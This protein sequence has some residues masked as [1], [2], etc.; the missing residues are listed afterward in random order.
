MNHLV[1]RLR[2]R[3][4]AA[5]L[6]AMLAIGPAHA[7]SGTSPAPPIIPVTPAAP[8]FSPPP[9]GAPVPP[10]TS[11]P[12]RPAVQ[13]PVAPA[14]APPSAVVPPASVPPGSMPP[15][16]T[17]PALTPPALTPPALTPPASTPPAA[18]PAAAPA[19]APPPPNIWLPRTAVSLEALDKVTARRTALTGKV[20]DTLHFGSLSIVVRACVVRP[21]DQPADAA[22]SLDITDAHAGAPGFDGWLFAAEPEISMFAHPL[23]DIRLTGCQ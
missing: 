13:T 5:A 12:A 2:R 15:A 22:A 14:T 21:P 9:A 7:Q 6:L 8:L 23:Y 11:A 3:F 1:R 17:P 10:V 19:P 4:P 20:G 16:S 18:P